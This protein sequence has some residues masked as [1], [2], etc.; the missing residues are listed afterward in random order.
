M[1][2]K[3]GMEEN[4][5]CCFG[6]LDHITTA[7]KPLRRHAPGINTRPYARTSKKMHIPICPPTPFYLI[8]GTPPLQAGGGT[9]SE[10]AKKN[11][12][13]ILHSGRRLSTPETTRF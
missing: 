13:T 2:I 9:D 7:A 5:C 1:K 10:R 3:N 11:L 8:T 12:K 4:F 6:V